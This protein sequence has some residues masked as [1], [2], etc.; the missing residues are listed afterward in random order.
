LGQGIANSKQRTL[1]GVADIKAGIV[2]NEGLT[3]DPDSLLPRHAEIIGWPQEKDA[4]LS[5]ALVLAA[6]ARLVLRP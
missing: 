3:V 5:I 1:Y 2:Q 6:E 4:Q